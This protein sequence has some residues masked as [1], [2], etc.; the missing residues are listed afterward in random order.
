VRRLPAS[1]NQPRSE[2]HFHLSRAPKFK[3]TE[4]ILVTNQPEILLR[5]KRF[6]VVRHT[7]T[8]SQGGTFTRETV[9]HPGS[10][11]VLPLLEGNRVCLIRNFRIAVGKTLIE[12]PAGTLE[13]Y[14]PLETAHRELQEET[15]YR[16]GHMEPL[17]AFYVSPGILNER[18][19]LFVASQLTA[20]T[21]ALEE[22][23]QIETL[24]VDWSRAMEMVRSGEI[25]DGKT[26]LGLLYFDTRRQSMPA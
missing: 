18:M 2:A 21:T 26:M 6:R 7:E 11:V 22:G 4:A 1:T 19:E 3:Q 23:E 17:C 16:A 13:G 15:G 25:E 9:Q 20:G 8:N 10:V 12:L 5:A 24:E 14:S